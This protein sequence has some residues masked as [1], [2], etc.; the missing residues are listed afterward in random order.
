MHPAFSVI[1]LTT[2]L[3]LSQGL[4]TALITAQTYASVE[5]VKVE[6]S[7]EFYAIGTLISLVFLVSALL[8][9]FFHLGRPERAWRTVSQWKTSWLSREVIVLPS[10]GLVA[11]IYGLIHWFNLDITLV[12]LGPLEINLSL[13]VG[14][15]AVLLSFTLFI[16]TA[17]IYAS[18][19]FLQEWATPLT[20]VNFA[21]LGLASGFALATAYAFKSAPS[22]VNMFA[23]WAI[24]FT[25]LA[26]IT[27]V[28][29]LIRNSLIKPKST[30][31]SAIGIR[32]SKIRQIAQGAMGGS[33]NTR[34]YFHG[35][36]DGTMKAVKWGFL[37]LVFL[38]PLVLITIG[39]LQHSYIAYILA[40]A[41]Q[42][43]GLLLERW[44]F[45]AQAKHPQNIY[46]Q[47]V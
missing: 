8:A 13:I 28:S 7:S 30:A 36:S 45:F 10:F 43:V 47:T 37:I 11:F 26:M 6:Q 20:L 23:G 27:K 24:I 40:V 15:V 33:Y 12:H 1:F 34:E 25:V 16:C 38:V 5:L 17:M 18:M 35:Q 39:L 44:F 41:V 9:S 2:L 19:R 42:Y 29:S 4:F 22:L 46:Y 3:G 32:H 21:L 14:I 31:S